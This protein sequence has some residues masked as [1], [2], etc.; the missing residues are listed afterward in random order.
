M[1]GLAKKREIKKGLI[2]P[3]MVLLRFSAKRPTTIVRTAAHNV[4]TPS[5]TYC[6][7]KQPW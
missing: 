3:W 5:K 1:D 4:P 7:I 2:L 6:G